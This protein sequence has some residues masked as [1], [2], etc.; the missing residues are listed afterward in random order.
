MS[1]AEGMCRRDWSVKRWAVPLAFLLALDVTIAQEAPRYEVYAIRFGVIP[2]FR[3]AGLIAGADQA[4]REDIPVMVW[5]LKGADGRNVLVDSGFYRERFV[6]E[7]KIRDF[8]RPS[9]ALARAG[10]RPEDITDIIVTHMHWDHAGG[11]ELFPRAKV[12]IQKEEY[13]YYTG[14]AWHARNTHGGVFQ[15]DVLAIVTLNTEGRVGFVDGDD[16]EPVPGVRC[17]TGGRHTW[18]SQYAAVQT[19]RGTIVLASDNAYLYENFE[20]RTPIAQTLDPAANLAAQDR[21]RALAGDLSRIVPGHDP[22]VF[23]KFP[24]VAPGVVRID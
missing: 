24:Q 14:P 4:R 2:G 11:I 7:W 22:A 9:V 8:E 6:T 1:G 16:R 10:L 19:R 21:I 5:L 15:E 13:A 18:A 17:Y 20:K 3:I 12:W 23:A